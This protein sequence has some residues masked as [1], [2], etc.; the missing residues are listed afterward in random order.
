MGLNV[1]LE[2]KDYPDCRPRKVG[3]SDQFIANGQPDERIES[4]HD[5]QM[6]NQDKRSSITS[7]HRQQDVN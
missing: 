3:Q 4:G 2:N 5:N 7:H 1:F 6:L